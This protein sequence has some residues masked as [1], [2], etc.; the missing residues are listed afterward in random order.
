MQ[1]PTRAFLN[2]LKIIDLNTYSG[3]EQMQVTKRD[4]ELTKSIYRLRVNIKSLA[5]ES[6]IIRHE[7]S[8]TTDV[9]YLNDLRWH[10]VDRVRKEARL[11]QL[12][13]AF[14][15]GRSYKSVE[16]HTKNPVCPLALTKKLH[17]FL[18]FSARPNDRV[19]AEW[20][21]KE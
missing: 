21:S 19:V 1:R 18:P 17:R 3:E 2:M 20:L 7:M 16:A 11:A 4:P 13:L 15:K 10:K 12:A 5:E 6:R 8:K 9:E 14:I